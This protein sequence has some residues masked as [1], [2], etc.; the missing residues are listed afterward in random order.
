M[1]TKAGRVAIASGSYGSGT[2]YPDD[3]FTLIFNGY[4]SVG[5][6]VSYILLGG[7]AVQAACGEAT[8]TTSSTTTAVSGLGFQPELIIIFYN[9]GLSGDVDQNGLGPWSTGASDGSTQFASAWYAE[10]V[11]IAD[12]RIFR[13]N[14]LLSVLNNS[15]GENFTAAFSSFDS[16]GFTLSH[17]SQGTAHKFKY[18]AI[19]D[20]GGSFKVGIDTQKT[21]TGTKATTGVGFEP[22]AL[23]F[24]GAGHQTANSVQLN[25][26]YCT[27]VA[28]KT[29]LGAISQNAQSSSKIYNDSSSNSVWVKNARCLMHVT[30][31]EPPGAANAEA[32]VESFDSGGFTLDWLVADGTARKFGYVAFSGDE[33][34][35]GDQAWVAIMVAAGR[36]SDGYAN[37]DIRHSFGT[38]VR[39]GNA[40]NFGALNTIQFVHGGSI[41]TSND[42]ELGV[43]PGDVQGTWRI[44]EWLPVGEQTAQIIRYNLL[45]L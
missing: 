11:W 15:G 1:W 33:T 2:P 32:E 37:Q 23:L 18:L 26:T 8:I 17:A 40:V 16:G 41:I 13:D 5:E 9:S 21:S 6:L 29:L 31:A 42:S 10:Y 22:S 39:G 43:W 30:P 36:S 25:C 24:L 20:G 7:N 28:G 35:A 34:P 38:Q 3:G 27:G 45:R 14:A 12:Y 4:Q 44:Y 19:R